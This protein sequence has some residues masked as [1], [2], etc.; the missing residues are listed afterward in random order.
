[1]KERIEEKLKELKEETIYL[2]FKQNHDVDVVI[3][4]YEALKSEN[5]K[6]RNFLEELLE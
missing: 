6:Q 3:A 2:S 1:M 4:K 5:F